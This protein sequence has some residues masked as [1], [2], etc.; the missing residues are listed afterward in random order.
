MSN[1]LSNLWLVIDL[2][3]IGVILSIRDNLPIGDNLSII[4]KLVELLIKI[5]ELFY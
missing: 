2:L 4:V 3:L 1:F 5:D